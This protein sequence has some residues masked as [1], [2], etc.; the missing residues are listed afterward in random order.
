MT[1]W[2]E[3]HEK[4]WLYTAT[5]WVRAETAHGHNVLEASLVKPI[6]PPGPG[7]HHLKVA[8]YPTKRRVYFEKLVQD[9]GAIYFQDTLGDFIAKFNHPA[10]STATLNNEARNMLIPFCWVSIYHKIKFTGSDTNVFNIVDAVYVQSKHT[11]PSGC[12]IPMWFD[13]VLVHGKEDNIHRVNGKHYI[14]LMSSVLSDQLQ[15]RP[16]DSTS[17]HHF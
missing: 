12:T 16:L 14:F 15:S 1:Q 3:H 4:V 7:T 13:T 2:L 10:A 17:M 8:Q 6:G 5:I 9:Y 11:D